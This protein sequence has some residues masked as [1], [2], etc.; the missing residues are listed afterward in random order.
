MEPANRFVQLLLGAD[1]LDALGDL[2]GELEHGPS[3]SKEGASGTTAMVKERYDWLLSCTAS[4]GSPL[5]NPE[6]I[7]QAL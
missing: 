7:D 4:S 1:T 3:L 2:V 5:R 6:D